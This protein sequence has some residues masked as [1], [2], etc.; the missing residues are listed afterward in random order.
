MSRPMGVPALSWMKIGTSTWPVPDETV[1]VPIVK[2]SFGVG[3]GVM[4]GVGVGVLVGVFVGV[5]VAGGAPLAAPATRR[6]AV[7]AAAAIPFRTPLPSLFLYPCLARKMP[8]PLAVAM[9]SACTHMSMRLAV[10]QSFG[11]PKSKSASPWNS[12]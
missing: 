10:S 2:T 11:R 6:A 4:V 3:V 5:A 1:T 9:C 12:V 7:S 8:Q